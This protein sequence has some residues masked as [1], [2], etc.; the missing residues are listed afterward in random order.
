MDELA[1][2]NVYLS[3][4]FSKVFQK[5]LFYWRW[6]WILPDG[7]AL[8][9]DQTSLDIAHFDCL[10]ICMEQRMH[11]LEMFIHYYIISLAIF[12][13][14]GRQ[15]RVL[16]CTKSNVLLI[17][18]KCNHT[19]INLMHPL[20]LYGSSPQLHFITELKHQYS[21]KHFK[22]YFLTLTIWNFLY[23]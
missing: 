5:V 12:P 18:W 1:L 10:L 17:S 4:E 19:Q 14:Y 23:I 9:F 16:A 20:K 13:V 15:I 7:N 8:H 6:C 2:P 3:S 22:H 11:H 21:N